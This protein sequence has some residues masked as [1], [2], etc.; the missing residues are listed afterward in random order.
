LLTSPAYEQGVPT[1]VRPA[2]TSASD[3]RRLLD[4]LLYAELMVAC[5]RF[6]L[7]DGKRKL[8][9]KDVDQVEDDAYFLWRYEPPSPWRTVIGTGIV[10][11]ALAIVMFPLWPYTLRLGV[12][13]VA[14]ALL[15]V[16]VAFLVFVFTVRPLLFVVSKWIVPPGIWILPNINNEE[17][18]FFDSFRPGWDWDKPTTAA[19]KAAVAA[20]AESPPATPLPATTPEPQ[21]NEK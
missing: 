18:G 1:A 5:D 21:A 11:G 15:V 7:P 8:E 3:A 16:V 2:V 17:L 19:K 12:S 4:G 9:V 14:T 20:S 13:Y 6:A 10:L